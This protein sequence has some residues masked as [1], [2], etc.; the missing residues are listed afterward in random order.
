MIQQCLKNTK[1][2]CALFF[3]DDD[4][5][6]L[7]VT[8]YQEK[9]IETIIWQKHKRVL[10]T[11]STRAGK[12]LAVALGIILYCTFNSGKN[13]RIIAPTQEHTRI[14]MNYVI[15][16]LLDSPHIMSQ[17]PVMEGLGAERLKKE[18]SKERIKFTN[19]SEIMLL[20]ANISGE[21]K[22]LVGQG[23]DLVV[24]DET[25]LIPKELIQTRIMR[26]L[27]DS[28]DSTL[29]CISNPVNRGFMYEHWSDKDWFKIH[30]K[31]QDCIAEGRLSQSFID[32]QRK[33]MTSDDFKIWYDSDWVEDEP[34]SIIKESWVKMALTQSFELERSVCKVYMGVDPA[35]F[36]RDKAVFSVVWV[37]EDGRYLL[38]DVVSYDTS[39]TDFLV[40]KV[41]ELDEKH[42]CNFVF[43]DESGIGGGVVDPLRKTHI[44]SKIVGV[45]FGSNDRMTDLEKKRYANLKTK[46]IF[47]LAN[48][49]EQGRIS[50]KDTGCLCKE[51]IAWKTEYV[52]DGVVG[53]V[54][55]VDPDKSPDF[56]DSLLLACGIDVRNVSFTIA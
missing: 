12:S 13:V 40:N 41:L 36:G 23:G 49:F 46:M 16:H 10:C 22:S 30:V 7:I 43:I 4:N 28:P 31:W 21:G 17:L 44:K 29:F 24:I 47:K 1:L 56:A 52:S 25:E 8:K 19:N 9:I 26:M 32:E 3:K 53:K 55:S 15:Q 39:S 2:L 27:G 33:N 45:N 34:D 54:K 35:R 48:I 5:K 18:L 50:I 51:L 37:C 11:A 14:I 6:P 42:R 38:K 20:T